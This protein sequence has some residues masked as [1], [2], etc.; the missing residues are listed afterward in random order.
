MNRCSIWIALTLVLCGIAPGCATYSDRMKGA[1]SEV[2]RGNYKGGIDAVDKIIGVNAPDKMPTLD[3]IP[4]WKLKTLGVQEG[5][6]IYRRT[7][8]CYNYKT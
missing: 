7:R 2:T 5:V 3:Q 4:S 1:R 6:I 8:Y